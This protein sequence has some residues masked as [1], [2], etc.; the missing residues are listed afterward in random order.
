MGKAYFMRC[1]KYGQQSG[2][3]ITTCR[4]IN[5]LIRLAQA[6]ARLC[7]RE[8]VLAEDAIIAIDLVDSTSAAARQLDDGNFIKK[9]FDQCPGQEY[10]AIRDRWLQELGLSESWSQDWDFYDYKAV[11]KIGQKTTS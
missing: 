9:G 11:L 4:I 5:S 1:R 7:Y 2:T 3:D 6:H 8:E 10:Q